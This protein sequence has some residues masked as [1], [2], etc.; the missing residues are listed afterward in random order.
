MAPRRCSLPKEC[1]I[2]GDRSGELKQGSSG[3][4][5]NIKLVAELTLSWK[6]KFLPL[7]PP[8]A[9]L[10]TSSKLLWSDAFLALNHQN[11]KLMVEGI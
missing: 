4:I 5:H 10:D 11:L 9:D 1:V 6:I 7:N 2:F 8:G 3:F